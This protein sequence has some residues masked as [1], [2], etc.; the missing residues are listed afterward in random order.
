MF[1]AQCKKE[2]IPVSLGTTQN[3]TPMDLEQY[4]D[5]LDVYLTGGYG[6]L[7]DSITESE[8]KLTLCKECGTGLFKYLGKE[9]P[10]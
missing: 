9:I 8:I 10:T 6:M 5:S 2:L 7:F 4:E 3:S 1:C